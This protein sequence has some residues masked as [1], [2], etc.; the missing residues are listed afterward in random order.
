MQSSI[1]VNILEH[2]GM[3]WDNGIDFEVEE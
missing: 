2:L 3:H 1:E